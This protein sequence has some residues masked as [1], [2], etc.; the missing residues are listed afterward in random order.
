[1]TGV[2]REIFSLLNLDTAGMEQVKIAVEAGDLDAAGA[3]Y[4]DYYRNRQ[5]PVLPWASIGDND[6]AA[7]TSG[8]DF[9]NDPPLGFTWRD[10]QRVKEHIHTGKGYIAARSAAGSL[11]SY[12]VVD[13]ADLLLEHKVFIPYHHADG[14]VDLGAD[15]DWEVVPPIEGHRWAMSL[16]YQYFLK[17]LAVSFWLTDDEKY[18][19]KL[20]WIYR[21]YFNCVGDRS[22]WM[23]VPDMQLARNYQQLLPFILS[24]ENLPAEDLCALTHWLGTFCAACMEGTEGAPGN[25][26][27]FNGI[28]LLWIGVGLHEFE[29]SPAWREKGLDRCGGY[30]APAGAFY[31]DGSARENSLGYTVGS[32][33]SGLEVL[34]LVN[35]NGWNCSPHIEEAMIKRARF[36]ADMRRP[37]GLCPQTGDGQQGKP[38][39]Y[40][41]NMIDLG[42]DP[43]LEYVVST[44][45]RGPMPD[46]ESSYYPWMGTCVMRSGWGRDANFLM[47]DMGPLGDIH[48]HEAKLAIE[49]AAFGRTLIAD[50]GVHTYSREERHRRWY[51]FLGGTRGHSTVTVDGL[52]QMRLVSDRA[53]SVSEPL[54]NTWYSSAVCDCLSG[55]Y[56]EGWGAVQ[57]TEPMRTGF[58]PPPFE[59]EIDVWVTHRRTV[60]Y[61]KATGADDF[62][63]WLVSDRL[64]GSAE[65]VYEQLFHFVPLQTAI[66]AR[67]QS[68]LTI[69]PG[70]ANLALVPVRQTGLDVEVA[71]GI[72]DGGEG[73]QGWH[74]IGGEILPAPCAIFKRSG[75]DAVVMQT[76]LW[77]LRPGDDRLPIVEALGND[78]AGWLRV[79]LPDS[80]GQD[81]ICVAPE[82]GVHELAED[83]VAVSFDGSAALVRL[84]GN[85]TPRSWEVIGRG[86][87]S[88]D[89]RHLK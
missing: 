12:T 77:P 62:D 36:L 29:R 6:L 11:S 28:G 55:E 26:L 78:G 2:E 3:A 27:L 38:D 42:A 25:Q 10:R 79:R 18:I 8:Y 4:L 22:D 33:N 51:K 47:C 66:D 86:Q 80:E 24:W 15:W 31:P 20:V 53:K 14:A 52:C 49:V 9:L 5:A 13:L 54:D 71:E 48:A 17:T 45:E 23:W 68:V 1:M 46:H 58:P 74:V 37:D 61:V 43:S 67:S 70:E 69:T 82:A 40:L 35:K 75:E 83:G 60:I 73:V 16:C 30:F 76:I 89:G 32:S 85:G 39:I 59:G 19:D 44:G 81:I 88:H 65:H 41:S 84:D 63:Y 50:K 34:L 7:R 56:D 64:S 72:D 21:H 87:L 57:F